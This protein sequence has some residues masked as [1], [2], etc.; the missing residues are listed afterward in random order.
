MRENQYREDREEL[1][2]LLRQYQNLKNG[3]KHSFLEEDDFERIIDHFD[4]KDDLPEALEAAEIGLSQFPYSSQLMIKK[5]DLL[6]ATRK[7]KEALDILEAAELYDSSDLNLYILKTDAYLALDQQAKAVELLRRPCNCLKGKKGWT[8]YLNW[9][10][11]M[12][13][14]RNSTKYSTV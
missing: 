8:S 1:K 6:L 10:M 7:Y 13:I 9:Q 3:R 2:E 14:M 4:E 11:F 12:T 5:A